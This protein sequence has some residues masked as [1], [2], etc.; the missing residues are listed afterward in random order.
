MRKNILITY[1]AY[2]GI[3][4]CHFVFF[5]MSHEFIFLTL[6]L[7]LSFYNFGKLVLEI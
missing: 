2:Q 3:L 4:C 5:M 6:I 1:S 7:S